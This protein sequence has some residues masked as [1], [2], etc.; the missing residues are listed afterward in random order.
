MLSMLKEVHIQSQGHASPQFCG[1]LA[2]LDVTV[3]ALLN[4]WPMGDLNV[5]AMLQQLSQCVAHSEC[6]CQAV[7]TR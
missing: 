4:F 7:L 2:R 3:A 1:V 6:A 5:S